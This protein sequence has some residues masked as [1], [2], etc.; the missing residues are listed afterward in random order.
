[1][2]TYFKKIT[3]WG[4]CLSTLTLSSCS[5]LTDHQ[6]VEI[7]A[8]SISTLGGTAVGAALGVAAGHVVGKM[9]GFDEK[10]SRLIGGVIGGVVGF[11]QGYKFGQ[12]WTKSIIRKKEAYASNE[13]YLEA[14][15]DQLEYRNK[16]TIRQIN[17]ITG[18]MNSITTKTRAKF[19][20]KEARAIRDYARAGVKLIDQDLATARKIKSKEVK[21]EEMAKLKAEIA[22]LSK[23]RKALQAQSSRIVSSSYCA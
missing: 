18:L 7:E 4:L 5:K 21:P 16:E 23:Q 17:M 13:A 19:S 20:K 6:R 10:K 1:M 8:T 15:I 14:N 12:A 3:T 11:I 22:K 9:A 2:N